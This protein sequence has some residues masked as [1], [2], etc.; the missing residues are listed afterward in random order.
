MKINKQSILYNAAILCASN[1][2]IQ[3]LAFVY[4]VFLSRLAGAEGV[5]VYSL[6][7]PV[8]SI[9][10]SVSLSGVCMAVTNLS[11]R[12]RA[13]GDDGGIHRLI[14][15]AAR[16]FAGVFLI[17]AIPVVLFNGYISEHMLGDIRAA[18]A[19]VLV[20]VCLFLTGFE[21]I[22]KSLFIG[23]QRVKYTAISETGEFLLRI[24]AVLLL[25]VRFN[26][27]DFGLTA[28]LIVAGMVISEVFS[29][30]FLFTMY[31][32]E[33][34]SVSG[35]IKDDGLVREMVGIAV[36]V[37]AASLIVNILGSV[38][39]LLLPHRLM[40][41]GLSRGDAVSALG[42]ISNMAGPLITLPMAI[43]GALCSILMP[44]I[45][46]S[47]SLARKGDVSKKIQKGYFITGIVALPA[48]AVILP[49]APELARLLFKQELSLQYMSLL[50]LSVVLS[51]YR[52]ITMCALNGLGLQKRAMTVIVA[53]EIIG[54]VLTYLLAGTHLGVTGYIIS[55]IISA[56]VVLIYNM[57]LLL[58]RGNIR[59]RIGRTVITPVV[60]ALIC[61]LFVR[62]AF[63][64]LV[65]AGIHA[66]LAAV[67]GIAVGLCIY[68]ALLWGQGVHPVKYVY[69]AL[70]S[71]SSSPTKA[72]E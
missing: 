36:P 66:G 64:S 63:A 45:A 65:D 44:S 51:Y 52:M 23:I 47:H 6:V 39:T 37:S 50:S 22:F 56:A 33:P 54:L 27:S 71:R 53:G 8:Y 26:S 31:R 68:A 2:A 48:T 60:T 19:L 4:R 67:S 34:C 57:A 11:A 41:S 61:G 20:M 72:F 30:I 62:F 24:T 40:A 28:L 9:V 10:V 16:I 46:V 58:R 12:M 55:G 49:M 5:G 1:L 17:V 69:T 29:V 25:L 70:F 59:L 21:N 35:K 7:F 13:K 42:V 15:N 14:I 3:V 43:V 38:N 32:R 18:R